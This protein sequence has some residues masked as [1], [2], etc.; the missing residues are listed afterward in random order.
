LQPKLAHRIEVRDLEAKRFPLGKGEIGGSDLHA[1]I[2]V[3]RAVRFQ[4]SIRN[5]IRIDL[6]V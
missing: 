3:R 4:G 1:V 2:I 6:A 5:S